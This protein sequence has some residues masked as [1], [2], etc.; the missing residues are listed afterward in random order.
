[1]DVT[2]FAGSKWMCVCERERESSSEGQGVKENKYIYCI[3]ILM[4]NEQVMKCKNQSN[5]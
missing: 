3:H 5:P 2:D 1:M 4:I